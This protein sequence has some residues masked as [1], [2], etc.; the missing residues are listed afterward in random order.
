[1]SDSSALHLGIDVVD[2]LRVQRSLAASVV[3]DGDGWEAWGESVGSAGND[4]ATLHVVVATTPADAD[5]IVTGFINTLVPM[6]G[7][8]VIAVETP[9]DDWSVAET[10]GRVWHR[11]SRTDGSHM[12][13]LEV[14]EAA[15]A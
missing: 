7:S 14:V 9:R 10:G 2:L 6:E 13:V 1:M 11:I 15:S 12:L 4:H 5:R 8:T 3:I